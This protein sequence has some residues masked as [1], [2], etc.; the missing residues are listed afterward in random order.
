MNTV[1]QYLPSCAQATSIDIYTARETVAGTIPRPQK[2][3]WFAVIFWPM[4]FPILFVQLNKTLALKKKAKTHSTFGNLVKPDA[5]E[6]YRL[7]KS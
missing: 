4:L 3:R 1:L 6:N 2:V 5:H 7:S